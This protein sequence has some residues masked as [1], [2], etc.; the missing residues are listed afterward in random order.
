MLASSWLFDQS[1]G[2][3][4]TPLAI[5]THK[6]QCF[7]SLTDTYNDMSLCIAYIWTICICKYTHLLILFSYPS[8]LDSCHAAVAVVAFSALAYDTMMFSTCCTF[9]S[10]PTKRRNYL[11]ALCA[12]ATHHSERSSLPSRDR[13]LLVFWLFLPFQIFFFFVSFVLDDVDRLSVKHCPNEGLTS[14]WDTTFSSTSFN[15]HSI[16]SRFTEGQKPWSAQIQHDLNLI[17][18]SVSWLFSNSFLRETAHLGTLAWWKGC[19]VPWLQLHCAPA[20]R[21]WHQVFTVFF[22]PRC[23]QHE[24]NI[25]G[26]AT[27]NDG[28]SENH[29]TFNYIHTHTDTM[30]YILYILR[31]NINVIFP[32]VISSSFETMFKPSAFA[33][34]LALKQ[35]TSG[36]TVAEP[37]RTKTS[38]QSFTKRIGANVVV[39]FST[40]FSS[41]FVDVPC[42]HVHFL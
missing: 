34:V 32:C 22:Q 8:L 40:S 7:G 20:L 4:D 38:G 5:K 24:K 25:E 9:V 30:I 42:I 29:G 27:E 17:K 18:I 35:G 15:Y 37:S 26:N 14:Q 13:R 3:E 39:Q 19:Q 2:V 1:K 33:K 21:V 23:G 36:P 16:I 11:P 28:K 12:D 10:S 31:Y 6:C 41:I